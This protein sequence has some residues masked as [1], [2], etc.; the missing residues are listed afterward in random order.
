MFRLTFTTITTGKLLAGHFVVE[1]SYTVP[2]E[3][4]V[5]ATRKDPDD[6]G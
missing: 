4:L 3:K 2:L 5:W 6:K 1:V